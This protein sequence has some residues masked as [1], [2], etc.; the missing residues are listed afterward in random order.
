M[1]ICMIVIGIY[2]VILR[3]LNY[4]LLKI[5]YTMEFSLALRDLFLNFSITATFQ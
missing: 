2:E 3:T 5:I 1:V 4:L